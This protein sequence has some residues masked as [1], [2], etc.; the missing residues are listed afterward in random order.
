[1]SY[2]KQQYIADG[3]PARAF[4]LSSRSLQDYR[5]LSILV[6]RL[7]REGRRIPFRLRFMS[8]KGEL[9][10]W[11]NV[12]CT[13]RNPRART[14]TYLSVESHNYRTV[15]DC[16]VLMVNNTKICVD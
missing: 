15:K 4:K 2:Y 14:H 7:D 3:T 13:S 9:I 11:D 1:M 12:V 16:L 5:K 8:L 6:T 10:E